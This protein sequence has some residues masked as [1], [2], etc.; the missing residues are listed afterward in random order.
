MPAESKLP[1]PVDLGVLR[2]RGADVVSFLQGQLSQ[3]VT[4]L[5]PDT[6]LLAGYHNPQGRVIALLRMVQLA[7]GDVLLVLPRELAAPVAARLSKY[8]L[9]A[10]VRLADESAH[11]RVSALVREV[12]PGAAP[13]APLPDAVE[14]A[15]SRTGDSH[16]VCVGGQPV[17]LLLF[18][19]VDTAGTLPAGCIAADAEQWAR[20][21]IGAGVPQ[22]FAATSEEFVAQMLNLDALGAIAFDKGCYTGQEVIA[23]AH[24][25]GRVKRRMQRFVARNAGPLAPGSAG[26]L[27]DGRTFKVVQSVTLPDGATEFLAVAP[28]AASAGEDAVAASEPPP[29][30]RLAVEPLPLPYALPE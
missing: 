15:V 24:F 26:V 4:R 25:R 27:G 14:G 29:A 2:V 10:K 12:Q 11:W 13:A 17:R 6:S 16:L 21:E 5:A 1:S 20:L 28:L 3:D 7:A 8:I 9:R 23:R 22:V 18:A 19:P 30:P